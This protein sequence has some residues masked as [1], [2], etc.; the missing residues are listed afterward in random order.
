MPFLRGYQLGARDVLDRM[1]LAK[2]EQWISA[3][4]FCGVTS[5][6]L[7]EEE[8]LGHASLPL[9]SKTTAW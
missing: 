6:M 1:K 3:M 4:G 7:S 9:T 2:H 8:K 5:S